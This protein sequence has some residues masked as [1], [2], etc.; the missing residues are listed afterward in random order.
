VSAFDVVVIGG[1]SAGCTAAARL[2]E[3][4]HRRVLLLE[5][6]GPA[7]DFPSTLVPARQP[8]AFLDERVLPDRFTV[9]QPAC[10][11][12][13]VFV[14]TGEVL[15]GSSGVNGM[16]WTRCDARDYEGRR[17]VRRVRRRRGRARAAARRSERRR[18]R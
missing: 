6:G 13:R 11:G 4:P 17:L 16:V 10:G 7:D 9:P 3:D 18:P 14:G 5:A 1:G 15:G 12:R 8:E 2:A